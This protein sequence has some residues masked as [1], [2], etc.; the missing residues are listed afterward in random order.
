MFIYMMYFSSICKDSMGVFSVC[1]HKELM[2]IN[3]LVIISTP[4]FTI[5]TWIS[6]I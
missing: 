5:S 6:N 1:N 2:N 3:S 4:C